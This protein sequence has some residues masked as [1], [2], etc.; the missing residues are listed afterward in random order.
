LAGWRANH[1]FWSAS[2][3]TKKKETL[4]KFLAK[5]KMPWTHWCNGQEGGI[6]EDWDVQAY[7][8]I[9]VLDAKGVIRHQNLRGEELE[10]AVNHL[11]K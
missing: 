6:I 4:T 9:Y 3:P 8:T 2:V 1:S 7:P 10:E 5:E 11:L